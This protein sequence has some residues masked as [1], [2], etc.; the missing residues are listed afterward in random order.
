MTPNNPKEP[1][2]NQVIEAIHDLSI[3]VDKNFVETH[4]AIQVLAES[5]DRRFTVVHSDIRKIRTS[6]VTK[7]YLD[8]KLADLRGDLIILTRRPN[9]KVDTL[10]DVLHEKRVISDADVERVTSASR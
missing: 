2:N 7:D 4:E 10:V 8:D 9:N 5:V 6:M 3:S 1:K